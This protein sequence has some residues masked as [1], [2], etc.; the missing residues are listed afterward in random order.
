MWDFFGLLGFVVVVI[1]VIYGSLLL[2]AWAL[3][4]HHERK[5]RKWQKNI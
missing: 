4:K 2:M 3:D 1:A 5:V